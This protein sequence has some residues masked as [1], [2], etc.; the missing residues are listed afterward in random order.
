MNIFS[1]F[2]PNLE[3]NTLFWGVGVGQERPKK[4]VLARFPV[5]VVL[6]GK[7]DMRQLHCK[8]IFPSVIFI[9]VIH[10]HVIVT[11]ACLIIYFFAPK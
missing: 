8:L 10:Q 3:G 4:K 6:D 11:L 2:Y 9:S 5:I 7:F 1:F